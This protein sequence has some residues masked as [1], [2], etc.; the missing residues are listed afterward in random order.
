MIKYNPKEW[1]SLIFQFHKSD[2]LRI[3][4]PVLIYIGL[5]SGVVAYIES[6]LLEI[7]ATNATAFHS[8]LGFVLSLLLVFRTNTAYERWWE[9]RKLWG[10]LVNN[11]RNLAAKLAAF[12][13]ESN[14]TERE[15]AAVLI[16]NYA[17]ALK[18]HLRGNN[19]WHDLDKSSEFNPEI[20]KDKKHLPNSLSVHLFSSINNLYQKKIIS[21]EQM[22]ILNEEMRSFNDVTG[23]CERIKNT[24]IPYSYSLFLKKFIFVYILTLPIGFVTLFGYWVIPIV[25][26]VFYVLA[27]LELI[28]EEIEDP[29][30]TDAND[31]PTDEISLRIKAN[32]KD[33]LEV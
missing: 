6:S 22:I 11:S 19:E 32:V 7:K 13:P 10:S 20:L 17:F 3:L 12:I 33:I 16:Y 31:L 15:N 27:S 21:G 24:P 25:M 4:F 8:L 9:G 1:F 28:A 29:F 23:A 26:F 5:Y 30:G 2:T 18:E 14:K